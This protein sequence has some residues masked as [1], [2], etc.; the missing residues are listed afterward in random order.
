MYEK[1]QESG[2]TEIIPHMHLT[3]LGP[4]SW[5]PHSVCPQGSLCGAATV[6]Q[7]LGGRYSL[8]PEFLQGSPTHRGWRLQS[9]MT[10]T[11]FVY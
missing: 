10:V 7:L 6:S 5:A 4:V 8:L 9:L 11:S 1:I 3:Y 2:L